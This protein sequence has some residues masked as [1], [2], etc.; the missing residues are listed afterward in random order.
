MCNF[1]PLPGSLLAGFHDQYRPRKRSAH[2]RE[3]LFTA[4]DAKDA[5]KS[6]CSIEFNWIEMIYQA[7]ADLRFARGEATSAIIPLYCSFN[8]V[9]MSMMI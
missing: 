2:R 7:K 3:K 5:K 9:A 1:S 6:E 4:E 8:C